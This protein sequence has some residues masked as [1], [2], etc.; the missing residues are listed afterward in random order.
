MSYYA[1]TLLAI[2]A[3]FMFGASFAHA[4]NATPFSK[5]HGSWSGGGSII[6]SDGT[7]ERIRCRAVYSAADVSLL[8]ELRCASDSYNFELQSNLNYES[9]S[10]VGD[11]TESSR[12]I[13][14]TI[15]GGASGDRIQ[16]VAASPMFTA[17]LNLT[18]QGDRQSIRMQSPGSEIS[19][20]SVYLNRISK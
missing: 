1:R 15:S 4:Q 20:I 14:G 5:L 9:G 8:L 3:A 6:L 17:T 2:L 16:V 7:K 10:I 13:S 19:E 11:W 18:T 12:G